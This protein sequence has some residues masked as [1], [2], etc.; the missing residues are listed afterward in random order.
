MHHRRLA[1]LLLGAWIAGSLFMAAVATGNF[2]AIDEVLESASPPIPEALDTLGTEKLRISLRLLAAEQNRRHF[3][4]WEWAQLGL[5]FVLALTLLFG[6]HSGRLMLGAAGLLVVLVVIQHWLL[7]PELAASAKVLELS[8][9]N[10]IS[11]DKARFEIY[12]RV[13]SGL[14]LVKIGIAAG[15][16][17]RLLLYRSRRRRDFR[18]KVDSVHHADHSGVN[19]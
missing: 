7:S 18:Q 8:Y 13:Y 10:E 2:R 6:T 3:A 12:H 17:A 4:H 1:T 11:A 15:L 9:P 16:A 19:R 5:G 14:E